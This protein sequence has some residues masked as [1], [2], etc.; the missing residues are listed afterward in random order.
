MTEGT[1]VEAPSCLPVEASRFPTTRWQRTVLVR[2]RSLIARVILVCAFAAVHQATAEFD[3]LAVVA[4]VN[5]LEAEVELPWMTVDLDA[6]VIESGAALTDN[7]T[8]IE[9]DTLKRAL[10]AGIRASRDM[11]GLF[12]TA[13]WNSIVA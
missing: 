13:H 4:L 1:V 6:E 5:S 11:V 12:F 2:A 8:T 10:F 3:T 7:Y 9:T